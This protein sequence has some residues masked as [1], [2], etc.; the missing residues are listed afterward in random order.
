MCVCVYICACVVWRLNAQWLVNVKLNWNER[1]QSSINVRRAINTLLLLDTPYISHRTSFVHIYCGAWNCFWTL[2]F[3]L[4]LSYIFEMYKYVY[5]FRVAHTIHLSIIEF[6]Y[7]DRITEYAR[8]FFFFF[9]L[10][11]T[12]GQMFANEYKRPTAV[13]ETKKKLYF[14]SNLIWFVI[15]VHRGV[16]SFIFVVVVVVFM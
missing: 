8:C 1:N 4:S 9:S 7:F 12:Y 13:Y 3:S 11:T 2:F 10:Q 16:S 5:I 15:V 6:K 14:A